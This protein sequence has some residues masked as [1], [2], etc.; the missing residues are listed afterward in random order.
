VVGS[1][2]P[3]L[4][5]LGAAVVLSVALDAPVQVVDGPEAPNSTVDLQA[6][7]ESRR[8]GIEVTRLVDEE[9]RRF[10]SSARKRDFG[11]FRRI[12]TKG[13]RCTWF[14]RLE[15]Q[16]TSLAAIETVLVR[17]LLD[18]EQRL[19]LGDVLPT[20]GDHESGT[21]VP[22]PHGLARLGVQDIE[23]LLP[24]GDFPSHVVIAPPSIRQDATYAISELPRLVAGNLPKLLLADVDERQ[25]F[26]WV[27]AQHESY[28]DF[29]GGQ[30]NLSVNPQLPP[31]LDAIWVSEAVPIGGIFTT[32]LWRFEEKHGWTDESRPEKFVRA[33]R[34]AE[35][36]EGLW[37]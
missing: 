37:L 10:W 19:N 35:Q 27:D 34:V 9:T 1:S 33:L 23:F 4:D 32:H 36:A 14:L 8:I 30:P 3:D 13:I 22:V 17:E 5:A 11:S 15:N 29:R 31:G 20:D 12:S 25:L 18:L 2:R 24:H 26:V 28:L 7:Y 16:T 6:L 21:R